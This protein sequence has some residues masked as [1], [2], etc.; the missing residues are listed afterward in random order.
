MSLVELFPA[1]EGNVITEIVVP[2]L[3]FAV[4]LTPE[5]RALFGIRPVSMGQ[6]VF[7][8][9]GRYP[10]P[11]ETITFKFQAI[12]YR[13]TLMGWDSPV[14]SHKASFLLGDGWN[15]NYPKAVVL[16]IPAGCN[17]YGGPGRRPYHVAG[18][19]SYAPLNDT[20]SRPAAIFSLEGTDAFIN[21]ETP[22]RLTGSGNIYQSGGSGVSTVS[23]K[24]YISDLQTMID[25]II[26]GLGMSY[27]RGI[28]GTL[29]L[30]NGQVEKWSVVDNVPTE[31]MNGSYNSAGWVQYGYERY[32]ISSYSGCGGRWGFSGTLGYYQT[33]GNYGDGM[34]GTPIYE[35]GLLFEL[36]DLNGVRFPNI[37]TINNT[38][39]LS[40]FTGKVNGFTKAEWNVPFVGSTKEAN[41]WF[42]SRVNAYSTKLFG[43]NYPIVRIF[44]HPEYSVDKQPVKN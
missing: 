2:Q 10:R 17:L 29:T 11:T 20:R 15:G 9:L 5:S 12:N 21:T 32:V 37:N 24:E 38:I 13:G 8:T 35:P 3:V 33:E 26:G 4:N 22:L 39:D 42:G 18:T 25:P 40:E 28:S 31:P 14:D 34:F 27:P 43:S 23:L 41:Y 1:V 44:G 6:L 19:S 36:G 16:D 7:D 30:P